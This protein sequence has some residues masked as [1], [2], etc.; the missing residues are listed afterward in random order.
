MLMKEKI[1]EIIDSVKNPKNAE[2]LQALITF[3]KFDLNTMVSAIRSQALK[4][5]F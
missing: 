3:E 1:Q 5:R 2:S 4:E